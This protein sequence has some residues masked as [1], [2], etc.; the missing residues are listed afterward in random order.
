MADALSPTVVCFSTPCDRETLVDIVRTAVSWRVIAPDPEAAAVASADVLVTCSV[1]LAPPIIRA[2]VARPA[3]V[4]WIAIGTQPAATPTLWLPAMP[5]PALVRAVLDQLVPNAQATPTWRRKTDMIIGASPTIRQLLATLDR[6][7]PVQTPVIITG[8]SGVGKELVAQALHYAG[9][10]AQGPFIAINCAAIPENLVEAEFFGYQRGAF[11]G[12]T[13]SRA[14]AFESAEAGTLFLDEI[15]D[16]PLAMQ[17]KLLRVL[18]TGEV[19]RLGANEARKV[20]FRLISATNRDLEADAR[21]GRFREDL[22]YRIQVYP[23]R[24]APLRERI[25]DIPALAAHHLGVIAAREKRA[26]SRLTNAALEKLLAYGW[27]GN[28][29]ELVNILER[30]ALVAGDTA[31]DAE[32]VEF[33]SQAGAVRVGTLVPYRDAKAKFE[34]DYY[35]QLMQ[36]AAG[37]VSLAAKLGDKTRKEIYDALERLGLDPRPF[38]TETFS[39]GATRRGKPRRTTRRGRTDRAGSAAARSSRGAGARSRRARGSRSRASTRSA[40]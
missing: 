1:S 31:I 20:T 17:A 25:E 7:A 39:A 29:R 35:A 15:G 18:Q 24:V 21:D 30:S 14:G 38:R 5:T 2:I 11:T 37:N 12:A 27:P 28:V 13:Q 6:L 32:H 34:T 10:R 36:A 8:E 19:Q 23:V 33:P 16:M 26:P 40:A 4:P 22:F 9:P 3:E